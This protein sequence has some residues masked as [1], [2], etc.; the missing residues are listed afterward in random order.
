M[1]ALTREL[2]RLIEFGLGIWGI[3]YLIAVAYFWVVWLVKFI[4]SRFYR[5]WG[6]NYVATV[7]VIVPT[8]K[9]DTDVLAK[10]INL[11]LLSASEVVREILVVTDEREPQTAMWV[12]SLW[13]S[14]M[15]VRVIEAPR[16]K[17]AAVRLGIESAKNEIVV[18]VESDTFASPGAICKLIKPFANE[19]V[20]GVV[21]DQLI[22]EPYQSMVTLFNQW[23]ELVK[24]RLTVPALSIFGQVTVLGG[25]C[26]AYRREAVLPLLDS[27]TDERFL[28]KVCVSGDDGRLTSLLL[29]AG[30]R[31]VYQ[32]TAVFQ[33]VSPPTFPELAKQRLRWFR[34]SCRRTIRALTCWRE[35]HLPKANRF[36]IWRRLPALLQ[37][38]T[39]WTNSIVMAVI[40]FVT[41]RSIWIGWWFW[42]GRTPLG[43]YVRI[44]LVLMLGVTLTRLIRAWPGIRES[45]ARSWIFLL[46]FPWYLIAMWVVRLFA[47]VTMNRQGWITRNATNGGAPGGFNGNHRIIPTIPTLPTSDQVA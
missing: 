45:R 23:V 3:V 37:M 9:E 2:L 20:G 19:N 5:P 42:V 29:Q 15:R 18:V 7:T 1:I 35:P 6:N 41:V 31:C 40:L 32:K 12:Q 46:A 8:Y 30:W 16:G 36:W 34:N 44:T 28:G 43:I 21:G 39:V 27:M 4:T 26:V 38:L 11:I 13:G 17:R 10:C 25:R 24:Y 22:H 14:E 33:T 47:I